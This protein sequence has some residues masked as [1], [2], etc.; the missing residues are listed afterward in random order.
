[1]SATRRTRRWWPLKTRRLAKKARAIIGESDCQCTR[2]HF[3]GLYLKLTHF[4]TRGLPPLMPTSYM[5]DDGP[6]W[7]SWVGGTN[8]VRARGVR[9]AKERSQFWPGM[10]AAM[11]KQWGCFL[12]A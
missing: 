12:P 11:A 8:N 7:P 10:A 3:G 5:G 1:M 6:I 2:I 4:W 9:S